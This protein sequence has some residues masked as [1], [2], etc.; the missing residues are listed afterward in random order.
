VEDLAA[1]GDSKALVEETA[2]DAPQVGLE[3]DI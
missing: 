2:T 3:D 1:Q